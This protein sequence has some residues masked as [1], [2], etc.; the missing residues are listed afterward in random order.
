[1]H[2]QSHNEEQMRAL[3]RAD[4]LMVLD[5][6]TGGGGTSE[7]GGDAGGSASRRIGP[8]PS[9]FGPDS[10]HFSQIFSRILFFFFQALTV[11]LTY[12]SGHHEHEGTPKT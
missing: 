11:A 6:G 2:P 9:I 3:V 12:G 1:M 5:A 10:R 4:V 8:K 7:A